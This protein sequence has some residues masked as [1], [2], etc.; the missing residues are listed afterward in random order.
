MSPQLWLYMKIRYWQHK[1]L[2]YTAPAGQV[3]YE[4][5]AK[6]AGV[7]WG[8]GHTS[9]RPLVHSSNGPVQTRTVTEWDKFYP[10]AEGFRTFSGTDGLL[11]LHAR[12]DGSG[13]E[14]L[15]AVRIAM[16]AWHEWYFESWAYRE[17]LSPTFGGRTSRSVISFPAHLGSQ[18]LRLFAGQVDPSDET[19]F[20][21]DYEFGGTHGTIDAWLQSDNQILMKRRN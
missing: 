8:D 9:N 17:G 16:R 14:S 21:I 5:K 19:H 7:V 11:F 4:D 20:T 6:S 13:K 18:S 3:M 1:C 12:K 2:V 15:V 10:L